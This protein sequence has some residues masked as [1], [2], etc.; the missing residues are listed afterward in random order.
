MTGEGASSPGLR[1]ARLED[2]VKGWFV[3]AFEPTAHHTEACE[4]S[5]RRYAAGDRE[6]LHHHKVA[7]ELTV[8]VEGSVRMC[9]Q[10]FD[11]G[12]IVTLAP[13]TATD[14]EAL[15]DCL[16]VVVKTPGALDDKYAGGPL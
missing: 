13:G 12:S 7:T 10:T 3:G 16:C 4:V 6:G 15:T 9:G 14:F 11:S 5:V 8:V 2:M 1:H